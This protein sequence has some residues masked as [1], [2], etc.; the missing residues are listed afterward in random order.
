MNVFCCCLFLLSYYTENLVK[1]KI[2]EL[3]QGS[4]VSEVEGDLEQ[5]TRLH[6]TPLLDD[7]VL[8]EQKRLP[9]PECAHLN[10]QL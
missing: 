9:H 8:L 3:S 2:F 4:F 5:S 6:Q 10:L 1:A 7:V